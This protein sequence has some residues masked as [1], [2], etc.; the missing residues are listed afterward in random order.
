MKTKLFA[1]EAFPS[2]LKNSEFVLEPLHPNH[3]YLDY[4][5]VMASKTFLRL[6][7]MS[8]WPSDNFTL[9]DNRRDLQ[10]HFQ[11]FSTH[12]AYTYTILS[13]D[14]RICLGCVYL[15]PIERI[16]RLSVKE[17]NDL[18]HYSAFVRFWLRQNLQETEK[19]LSIFRTI[20][21]WF[22]K[23]WNGNS[24]IYSCN[25]L[26]ISTNKMFQDAGLKILLELSHPNRDELLWY[27]PEEM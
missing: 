6:W 8:D 23:S 24:I 15:N 27:L 18:S 4:E 7:S 9:E 19:E 1:N 17:R 11:E 25:R 26:L 2:P 16:K 20:I 12:L 5:A 10:M 22:K 21:Y 14:L 3:V 13:P